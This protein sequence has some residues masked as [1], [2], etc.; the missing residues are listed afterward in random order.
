M[1]CFACTV[2]QHALISYIFCNCPTKN[3]K[4]HTHTHTHNEGERAEQCESY[5]WQA[6]SQEKDGRRLCI[7][8]TQQAV[9]NSSMILQD[10]DYHTSF[11]THVELPCANGE[12]AP[13]CIIYNAQL[14]SGAEYKTALDQSP[15]NWISAYPGNRTLPYPGQGVCK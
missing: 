5:S 14:P 9:G 7:L 4:N 10:E 11:D 13:W 6:R 2:S 3:A 12:P 1:T 15:P 8:S